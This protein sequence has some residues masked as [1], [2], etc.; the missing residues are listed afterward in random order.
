MQP[1]PGLAATMDPVPDHG[2][3]S[4]KGLGR[5]TGRRALITGGDSGIGRAAAIAYAREGAHV[6]INHLPD[7]DR[8]ATSL[9]ELLRGEGLK[10]DALPGDISD[11]AFC[12]KLV[13]T[14]AEI[15]G[16]IDV[17]V[18]NAGKQVAQGSIE[19]ITTDQFD[20]TFRTNVH[21][22]FWLT[23]AALHH[24]QPGAAIINTTSVQGYDPSPTL[25]DYAMTKYAIIGFTKALAA[26]LADRGIRV[27]GVAPGPFW[28]P[29]QPSH[30]QPAEKLKNFGKQ[31]AFGRPG[32]PA[33]IAS[34]YVFLATQESGYMTGEIVGVTGGNPIH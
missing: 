3:D 33:E 24:M 9:V 12:Q 1:E 6:V 31:S 27:N 25:M 29:L 22:M 8:D 10:A 34:T 32:Q 11:E 15:M 28:T 18:N 4:Y 14:A 7:E 5:M 20:A 21:A 23:K 2:E 30:G 26:Q 17:L 19:D 13:S 16:G